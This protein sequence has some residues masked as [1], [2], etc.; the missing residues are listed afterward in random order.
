MRAFIIFDHRQVQRTQRKSRD[1]AGLHAGMAKQ[2]GTWLANA[3][4]TQTDAKLLFQGFPA[5]SLHI[6]ESEL[7]A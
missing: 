3:E 5:Q 2:L 4:F 7:P 1:H 6:C